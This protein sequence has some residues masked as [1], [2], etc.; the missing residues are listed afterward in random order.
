MHSIRESHKVS[1]NL[2]QVASIQGQEE[3]LK[4]FCVLSE[5]LSMVFIVSVW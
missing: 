5:I 3:L 1:L 2:R 4:L